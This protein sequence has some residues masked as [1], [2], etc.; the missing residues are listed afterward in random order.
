MQEPIL[1]V[2]HFHSRKAG[3][4]AA[5][6]G[7]CVA[8]MYALRVEEVL[9]V[10]PEKGRRDRVWVSLSVPSTVAVSVLLGA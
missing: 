8:H 7:G 3:T 1:G 4:E 10:W 6:G 5:S 9:P 2:F